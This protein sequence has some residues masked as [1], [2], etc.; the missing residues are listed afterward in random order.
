MLRFLVCLCVVSCSES[1]DPS[2]RFACAVREP[3]SDLQWLREKIKTIEAGD[4]GISRYYY[5][6]Q[7]EWGGQ[8][9]FLIGNCCPYCDTKTIAFNCQGE[10]LSDYDP[11][12][13]ID[14]KSVI[15]EP[16]GY[17]CGF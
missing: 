10:E 17:S 3:V 8:T 14:N 4:S 2:D 1:N 5:V 9:I 11:S 13:V 7:G 16:A 15:W 12:V 6:M